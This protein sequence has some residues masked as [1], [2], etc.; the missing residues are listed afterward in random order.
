M[1][2]ATL[3]LSFGIRRTRLVS[4][5]FRQTEFFPQLAFTMES[6]LGYPLSWILAGSLGPWKH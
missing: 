5:Q 1:T 4:E 6:I 2:L 3:W